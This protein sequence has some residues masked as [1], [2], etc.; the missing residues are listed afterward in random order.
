MISEPEQ[1]V[2]GRAL[3]LSKDPIIGQQLAVSMRRFAIAAKLCSDTKQAQRLL[4]T[5]K[6]DAAVVDLAG[7]DS[8]ASLLQSV[9]ASPSNQSAVTFAIV[10][11]KTRHVSK[12]VKAQFVIERD[13]SNTLL[14]NMLKVALGL[15]IREHRRYF[16]C[17]VDIAASIT[18]DDGSKAPRHHQKPQAK[19]AQLCRQARTSSQEISYGS[20]FV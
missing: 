17:S 7:S 19:E 9:R 1:G 12:D 15:I 13:S 16:R 2:A 8:A 4:N 3:L 6:F 18:L 11:A 10:D 14:S 20:T 5:H